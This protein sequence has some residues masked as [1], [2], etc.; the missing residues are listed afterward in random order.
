MAQR[1]KMGYSDKTKF[2][3]NSSGSTK[4]FYVP[5]N[6]TERLLVADIFISLIVLLLVIKNVVRF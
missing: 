1:G 2:F 6:L 4:Q 3:E 5:D